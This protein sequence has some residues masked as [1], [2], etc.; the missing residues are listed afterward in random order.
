VSGAARLR[1][2]GEAAFT[3]EL[4]DVI[5]PEVAARVRALDQALR[6]RAPAGLRETVPTYR[7]LLVLA[8]PAHCDAA[9]AQALE[10]AA[11]LRV[12]PQPGRRHELPVVYG[13][14]AGPDLDDAA[15]ACGLAAADFVRRHAAEEYTAFMLGFLPGFAYLGLLPPELETPRRASPRVRVP[16]GTVA[17]ARRQTAVYPFRSPG[18]WNLIGRTSAALFDAGRE[19]PA[20]IQPGDRV[21]F[22]AVDHLPPVA[23]TTG[24]EAAAAGRPAVEVLA[25]GLLT[26]VQDAGRAG[27]RRLGVPAA[28]AM[29]A[30]ALA[31]AN[32]AVG[33]AP[34]DA[35]LECTVAGPTVRFLRALRFALAGADLGALLER[36]DLGAWPV[37]LG[38]SVLARPGNVLRFEQR[39]HG[40]RAYLALAGGV[41]A[42]VV[43]GSRATDLTAG[44]GGWRGRPLRA[45]DVL[46]VHG[47]G[48][49]PARAAV[50]PPAGPA[51]TPELR[52][53]M[54][55]QDEAFDGEA[56]AT[57]LDEPFEVQPDSDR[58]GCRLS[59]PRVAASGPA[60]IVS[61]GMVPG[62]V[63]V[64]PSGQPIVMGPDGP[65]TGGYPK[66]ATVIGADLPRLAQL[67]PGDRV[68]FRAVGVAEA[69]R[70][71][72]RP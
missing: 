58:V 34:G 45:G 7:S 47:A 18:G 19:P 36:P 10:E 6:E 17:V 46:S 15:R 44:F 26:T 32:A 55:P 69:R 52:V 65:T 53:V 21:R 8:D 64:P 3:V 12:E 29:D 20:L 1:P 66:I 28:G 56:R 22:L 70:A 14:D 25:P 40:C 5:D 11:A 16:P 35:G 38:Q 27:W 9:A 68:R 57:F 4:G 31:R 72:E 2:V 48:S 63:Q 41:A 33:N 59:G 71:L 30:P 51:E 60:E 54:G 42:P 23:E 50:P 13:G 62:S 24:P 43:L 37:P 49:D 67:V 61:D 39:R